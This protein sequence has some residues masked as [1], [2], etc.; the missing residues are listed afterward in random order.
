[1]NFIAE[2]VAI[3]NNLSVVTIRLGILTQPA[4]AVIGKTMR[5]IS[6]PFCGTL[7]F[8]SFLTGLAMADD[9]ING[10]FLGRGVEC[11]QF[12]IATGEHISLRG[13]GLTPIAKGTPLILTGQFLR[14]SPC[15]QGR[16]FHI[17]NI[18]PPPDIQ[19]D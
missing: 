14:V 16:T 3:C 12:R 4:V 2:N 9:Q 8:M 6:I 19:N 11:P 5:C 18:S 10:T 13:D 1:L 15:M 17:T 7:I